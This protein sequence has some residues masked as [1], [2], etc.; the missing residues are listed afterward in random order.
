MS[1]AAVPLLEDD[2]IA[3][4]EEEEISGTQKNLTHPYVTFF[5]I[6]FRCTAIVVY[7]LCG[8]FSDSFITSFVT[9]ILLL[10]MDF[11]TVKNITGR[12]MVGLRWW[13]YVDD[14][15]KSHW[16][17]EARKGSMQNRINDREAN[18]F[19]TALVMCP[20]VW[21]VLFLVALFGLKLKW[22]LLVMIALILNGANLYGY[23]KCKV[24]Q[25]ENL[26]TMTGEF[27]KK[28]VF[29]NAVS[30]VTRQSTPAPSNPM[31]MPTNT[32]YFLNVLKMS[33]FDTSGF[34]SLAKTALKEAQKTI[35]KAL[36]IKDDELGQNSAGHVIATPVDSNNDD[37]FSTWGINQADLI[38]PVATT[39]LSSPEPSTPVVTKSPTRTSN[40]INN[41]TASLWGSFTGSFFDSAKDEYATV[42]HTVSVESLNDD[43]SCDLG[44]IDEKFSK[45]KLVV[46]EISDDGEGSARS[47]LSSSEVEAD[48]DKD[49]LKSA[50]LDPLQSPLMLEPSSS[51]LIGENKVPVRRRER[52]N[53]YY[54]NRLSVIS[55]ES[56][57]NSSESVEV[58]GPNS[59]T[60]CTT[61]PDS[62]VTS[63]A[64][65]ISTSS[66]AIGVRPC[67]DSVE[68][69]PDS[70]TSP[71]SVE[72]LGSE[73][74][75][76]HRLSQITDE[77]FVS[78][79]QSPIDNLT[80][81]E[82]DFKI[83][84]DSVEIIPETLEE[85]EQSVADDSIS[86]MSVSESTD[87]TVLEPMAMKQ[88]EGRYEL[89]TR[90][91]KFGKEMAESLSS[92]QS[93][94]PERNYSSAE[95]I[96]QAPSRSAMHL[97]L[98][99]TTMSH[100]QPLQSTVSV[101]T[102]KE[103]SRSTQSLINTQPQQSNILDSVKIIDIPSLHSSS[104]SIPAE[105]QNESNDEGSQSD[106][107]IVAETESAGSDELQT[108]STTNSSYLKNMIADAMIEKTPD[109][110]GTAEKSNHFLD[111]SQS[112]LM[113]CQS[114]GLESISISQLDMPPRDQSPMS[115]ESRSDLVK[116]GSEQTSGHTSGDELETTTSSDIEIISSPNGDSSSVQSGSRQSPAK[117]QKFRCS[118]EQSSAIEMLFGKSSKSK[119][120][121]HNREL[122]E[123]S[124]HSDDSH[125]SEIDRLLKRVSEMTEILEARE[126]KLIDTTRRNAELQELNTDLKHQLES[127]LSNQVDSAD[128][129]L[130]TEEYTQRLSALERKF[131]QAIREKDI[132]R[133]QLDQAKQD[134]AG[135]MSKGELESLLGD[136][137]E[138]IKELRHEG[139][140]LS[141]QQLQHSNIIK[142]LRAKEK[143]NESTI[144]HLKERVEEL[145]SE[146]DRLKRS[147][148]AKEE[149]ERSQIDAVHQ[150]TAKNKKLDIESSQL[151]SQ[152]DDVNQKLDT[153]KKSLDA[154]KKELSDKHRASS[155]L[156][157]RQHALESLENEKRTTQLQNEEIINQ[158]EDL[159]HKL[160]NGE[161]EHLKKE[162]A[163]RKENVNLL[164][165]IEDAEARNEELAQ[166]V[167]QATRPLIRQLETLQATHSMK[168]GSWETQEQTLVQKLKE[169][170]EK[171]SVVTDRE[172]TSREEC[173]TLRSSVSALEA[174]INSTSNQLELLQ[175]QVEQQKTENMLLQQDLTR[176]K[177]ALSEQ[178]K[179]SEVEI[180][181][182]KHEI[183]AVKEQSRLDISSLK[184]EE[185]KRSFV[186]ETDQMESNM[187][188]DACPDTRTTSPTLSLRRLSF[189]DSLGS[190]AWQPD[191]HMETSSTS[192]YMNVFEIEGLQSTLKQKEGEVH[193]LQW[194]LSRRENERTYLT[195][196]IS[197]LMVKMESLEARVQEHDTLKEQFSE[198]QQQYDALCQMYGEK[199][200]E[201]QE[202]RLDLQD[203]KDM[204]KSQID[205]LLKQSK[206]AKN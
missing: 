128:L 10:S 7:I 72:I 55:S 80:F 159:R 171:L 56:G 163:L 52:P 33:W 66:S 182:L 109:G 79:F 106:R 141:K 172:R 200:E 158:L 85:E 130:V 201:T 133:K 63:A 137:D 180:R 76:S 67:S 96:T 202:L 196:E 27:L 205:E 45:S 81:K 111:L 62:E 107:T 20:V 99:H 147:L 22:L 42:Q 204:Y 175:T 193:Q 108:E 148:T 93:L 26:T 25:K 54:L 16:V 78:P 30:L 24:G 127:I 119:A 39:S 31:S 122:S 32:S 132:L 139:E 179:T 17:Y 135:R 91:Q 117:M 199:V 48:E 123:A 181:D 129:N 188:Q 11:W 176:E 95:P 142:R 160:R 29:Q 14:E 198:L 12:L 170:Q 131:Q 149:V 21:S 192:R 112:M 189:S 37:F 34:A 206:A 185:L 173:L 146:T 138:T 36:D 186:Q 140:K 75:N 161:Q 183:N 156:Q 46:R 203:V 49:V 35:D 9:V 167:S 100:S 86:Y 116:I 38:K 88:P 174:K 8:W 136:K 69:L 144:K 115:S 104:Q 125:S 71:S 165:R 105:T 18:I 98:S 151:K 164:R 184:A 28:Q 15:G 61:T 126:T 101:N 77:E 94:S 68:V 53:S 41:M 3:F 74:T 143:E 19:W 90:P 58:L 13:N 194:E 120:K 51:D 118:G 43:D 70:L 121:G 178:L 4:G 47:R 169:A 162:Q 168:V 197:T 102:G 23:I 177:N 113:S 153:F 64:H 124:S 145:T 92:E 155:E 57:K 87:A 59:G 114:D 73:A 65:S 190:S 60:G 89:V 154:A 82:D 187:F 1:S 103:L 83:S 134:A 40:T 5:H 152:L 50:T 191:D 166:S 84:P 44:S 195:T 150:L 110:T 97:P 6:A 157:A 2:T